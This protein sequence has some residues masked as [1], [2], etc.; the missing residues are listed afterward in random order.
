MRSLNRRQRES[1]RLLTIL[2]WQ[3]RGGWPDLPRRSNDDLPGKV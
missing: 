3:V 1:G 2:E